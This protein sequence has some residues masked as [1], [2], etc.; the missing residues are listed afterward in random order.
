MF[1]SPNKNTT[2]QE[3]KNELAKQGKD[4]KKKEDDFASAMQ[5]Q[6]L[7]ILPLFIGFSSFKLPL[8]LS[9]YWNTLT[10]FGIIQQYQIMGWGGLQEWINRFK[11]N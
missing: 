9:L 6:T 8:G 4:Q 10:I 7:Y 2:G 3:G 11:K 1:N 5:S